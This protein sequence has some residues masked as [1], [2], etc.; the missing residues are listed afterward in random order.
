MA[1]Y[2]EAKREWLIDKEQ[3]EKRRDQLRKE[4]EAKSLTFD[5]FYQREKQRIVE[6]N[7]IEPVKRM[8]NE[9]FQLSRND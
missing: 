2:D 6:G 9:S 8:Y 5:E 3:S 4:R 7:M 1:K